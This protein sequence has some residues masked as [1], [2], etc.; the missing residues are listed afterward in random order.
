MDLAGLT[1][2]KINNQTV[3]KP[4]DCGDDDLNGFLLEKAKNYSYELLATTYLLETEERTIAF[5]SI[6]NDSLRVEERKFASK[7]AFKRLL[8]GLV[9]HP[10]RHLEDFPAIKIGRLAVCNQTQTKGIG[11]TIISYIIN[12]ALTQNEICACKLI[13]VDAYTQSLGF[14][15]KLGFVYFSDDD[16]GKDTRQ[17]YFDLTP[18]I[19]AVE[20]EEQP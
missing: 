19:N 14:Y 20:E 13:T 2:V 17:M 8:K 3:I 1:L 7:S 10:K 11:R 6:F 16:Y 5:F 15:E 12:L 18:F 4:F 9:S